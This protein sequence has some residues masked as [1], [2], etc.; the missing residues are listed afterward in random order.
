MGYN[1]SSN[2][3]YGIQ[4]EDLSWEDEDKVQLKLHSFKDGFYTFMKCMDTSFDSPSGQFI[5]V[6]NSVQGIQDSSMVELTSYFI[7]F[8]SYPDPDLPEMI[9]DVYS[10]GITPKESKPGWYMGI[11]AG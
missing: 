4:I 2:A 1:V 3:F 9:N 11:F 7:R 5:A 10:L 6:K 8:D